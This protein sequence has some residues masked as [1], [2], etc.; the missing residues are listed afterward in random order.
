MF[1]EEKI[2]KRFILH[3]S[4]LDLLGRGRSTT[5]PKCITSSL[6]IK[7]TT[8]DQPDSLCEYL[9]KKSLLER[10]KPHRL[11]FFSKAD[12]R[13]CRQILMNRCDNLINPQD[14]DWYYG[15]YVVSKYAS[16]L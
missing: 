2:R 13:I 15:Y 14:F 1:E 6:V 8:R 12:L 5:W 4:T 3:K 7:I 10:R 11:K 16:S 9:M